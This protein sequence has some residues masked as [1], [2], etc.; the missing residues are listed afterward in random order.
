MGNAVANGYNASINGIYTRKRLLKMFL[1]RPNYEREMFFNGYKWHHK[2]DSMG[3]RNPTDRVYGEILLLGDSMI[4]GHGVD[5]ASTVRYHL[6][7]IIKHPVIN[8]GMQGN[9]IHQEYQILKNFG[10]QYKPRYVFL[11]FLVND[12][13]DITVFLTNEEISKFLDTPMEIHS[14]PYYEV[15][16]SRNKFLEIKYYLNGLYVYRAYDLL[17]NYIREF[18]LN[19]LWP[20]MVKEVSASDSSWQLLPFFSDKPRY[21]SAMRFHLKAL[22]KIQDIAQKNN[23]KFVNVFIYTGSG[24]EH[25]YEKIMMD[26]CKSHGIKFLSLRD[27]FVSEL[28]NGKSLFLKGDGHFSDGGAT[29]VAKILVD[30]INAMECSRN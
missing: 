16:S 18:E 17:K 10:I 9:C 14:K 12:I 2:T 22:L 24:E 7:N 5:D 25:N 15:K 8:L 21:I 28:Q 6:E 4:Y 13:N 29:L 20:F 19:K 1:M 30:Y 11:F 3:F 26:Y 23:F 27:A